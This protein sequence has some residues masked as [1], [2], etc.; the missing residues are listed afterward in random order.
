MGT[1]CCPCAYRIYRYYSSKEKLLFS[2]LDEKLSELC[3][4]VA[5][6]LKG[7]ES[8]EE[9]FRKLFW[10]T[11]DHYDNVPGMAVANYVT[12]PIHAWMEGGTYRRSDAYQQI[13]SIIE[14]GRRKNQIDPDITD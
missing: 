11:M 1:F 9:M 6:H 5:A 3:G 7:M 14:H 12:A 2:I 10:V 4:L 8:T 13:R